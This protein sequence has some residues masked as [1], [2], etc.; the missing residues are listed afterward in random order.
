MGVSIP[1][2]SGI[3]R[4]AGRV[5]TVDMA[6]AL[7]MERVRS[8]VEVLSRAGLDIASFL[9]EIE[10]S[11]A[12]AVPHVAACMCTVDP[13]TH[14]LTSTYKFGDLYGNDA[15]DLLWGLLEY[16]V[17][18]ETSFPRLFGMR[19]DSVGMQL[20][21][22]GD[23]LAS[24]RM[25][26][27]MIP[28]YGYHDEARLIGR[29][30]DL[31]W[32]GMALFRGRDEP[33]FS[34]AEIV[35]LSTLSSAYAAGL[36][37][38][39]LTRLVRTPEHLEEVEPDAGPAVAI[40]DAENRVVQVSVGASRLLGE[41]TSSANS[42]DA[43]GTL[44]ALVAGARQFASG[45]SDVLPRG[46]VRLPSGRWLVLHASPL[47][48]LDGRVG[49]VV[50]TM[51]EARPPEIVPLVVA[52]FGLTD[53]ERDVTRLVLQGAD[54]KE[55]AASLHMSR[56]TVQD[57]LKAVFDKA[58]VRSRRELVSRVYF[59][60]YAPRL[61]SQVAPSGWFAADSTGTDDEAGLGELLG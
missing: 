39:L 10:E 37:L 6:S 41:M 51:E 50:I 1:H 30:G 2:R 58:D 15:E 40:V 47:S 53:R 16:G 55:I 9:A 20:E 7:T 42:A 36:R 14:L 4:S 23:V 8:D 32:G 13:A 61:G 46:R 33:S 28:I 27:L 12:R 22:G 43:T 34:S 59:D 52:A 3:A 44:A 26:E 49:E 11:I 18:E 17:A 38:G 54:T 57:H 25:D 24:R 5:K 35:F 48:S 31:A 56:Y 21:T 60:Q 19:R 29:Q 45:C